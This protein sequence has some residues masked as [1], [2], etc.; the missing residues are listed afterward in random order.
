MSFKFALG[1]PP[2]AKMPAYRA[3][4]L[5]QQLTQ[6]DAPRAK[7]MAASAIASWPYTVYFGSLHGQTNDSD[8]GGDVA[9]CTSSQA[10]QSGKYGPDAA[11][12]YAHKHGL[13]NGDGPR[14]VEALGST[15]S[16]F[17]KGERGCPKGGFHCSPPW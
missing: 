13:E 9:T 11:F 8:G 5:G 1:K 12:A 14:E 17:G 7:A 15:F 6:G 16:V 10:A 2:A 3:M 4:P